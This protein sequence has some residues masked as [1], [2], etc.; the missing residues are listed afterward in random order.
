[1]QAMAKVGKGEAPPPAW[2][3][4]VGGPQQGTPG[5]LADGT[6]LLE[7]G[8][9]VIVCHVPSPG[10]GV[11][12]AAKGM[13]KPLTV[14]P[15]AAA[16]LAAEARAD[17][18]MRLTDYDF[19][20]SAPITAGRRTVRIVNQAAQFHEVF[21]ARLAPGKTAQDAMRWIE[22]GMQGPP[23]MMPAGGATGMATGRSMQLTADFAPGEY[24]LLCFLPD[25]KDGKM[26]VAHGMM[27]QITVR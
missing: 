11:P 26:H 16:S 1:M 4:D 2:A 27:K 6:L 5:A 7:A 21:I 25:A 9:Y 22:G 8:N 10:D 19:V 3:I 18:E 15:V 23:P 13:F 17:V 24:A 20:L 14:T 12:H